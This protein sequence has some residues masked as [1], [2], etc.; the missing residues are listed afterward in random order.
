MGQHPFKLRTEQNGTVLVPLAL[1]RQIVTVKINPAV[2]QV[3]NL[4][5]AEPGIK[6][7]MDYAEVA[8]TRFRVPV[9]Q[10]VDFIHFWT[11]QGNNRR[12]IIFQK[13]DLAQDIRLTVTFSDTVIQKN[14]YR[15]EICIDCRILPAGAAEGTD[16]PGHMGTCYIGTVKG[17]GIPAE[18]VKKVIKKP[19][20]IVMVI[21]KRFR[22]TVGFTV[23]EKQFKSII[24]KYNSTLVFCIII[25]R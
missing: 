14:L 15:P 6:H 4:R 17:P 24:Q 23:R 16:K 13:L 3:Y 2:L 9:K 12:G 25:L 11:G 10:P 21:Y 18:T 22:R 1:Y 5:T 20:N 8:H 19:W 7:Q